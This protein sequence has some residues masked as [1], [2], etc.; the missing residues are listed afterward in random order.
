M[1]APG[2]AAAA[3]RH[4]YRRA[5]LT[6]AGLL[7]G[8][9]AARCSRRISLRL[10]FAWQHPRRSRPCQSASEKFLAGRRATIRLAARQVGSRHR[11]MVIRATAAPQNRSPA[12]GRACA[13]CGQPL[14]SP[15]MG[16]ASRLAMATVCGGCAERRSLGGRSGPRPRRN[17]PVCSSPP[18]STISAA[19]R[20]PDRTIEIRAATM[21]RADLRPD[22]EAPA[23]PVLS[24]AEVGLQH[25]HGFGERAVV[26]AGG[27][28]AQLERHD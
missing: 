12:D 21:S 17:R 24:T 18:I 11:I 14:P 6:P 20:E 13:G 5:S 8:S 1:P 27:V 26:R 2:A 16:R 15:S 22:R 28:G 10:E 9:L 25:L 23:V 7:R 19:G 3:R 4:R